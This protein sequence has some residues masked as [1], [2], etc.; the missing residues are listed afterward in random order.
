[1]ALVLLN[2]LLFVILYLLLAALVP[3]MLRMLA[4]PTTH[5]TTKE[6][7]KNLAIFACLLVVAWF[8]NSPQLTLFTWIFS[9]V[10]IVRLVYEVRSEMP[11]HS[12]E[13]RW[14]QFSIAGFVGLTILPILIPIA[15]PSHAIIYWGAN[16]IGSLVLAGA[17]LK[18]TNL[19]SAGKGRLVALAAHTV[20][21][22]VVTASFLT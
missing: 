18:Y 9:L 14:L 11:R 12:R 7:R 16:L 8:A 19:S 13:Q 17:W 20:A 22:M 3:A 6:F 10:I 21:I 4:L 15:T 2:P 5:E 1:M